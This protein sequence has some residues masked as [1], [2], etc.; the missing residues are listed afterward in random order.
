[1]EE[2]EL[3]VPKENLEYLVL[4]GTDYPARRENPEFQVA[5]A[6]QGYQDRKVTVV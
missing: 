2:M 3:T 5:M 1:M 4:V 6:H